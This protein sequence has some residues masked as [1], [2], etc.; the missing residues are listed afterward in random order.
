MMLDVVDKNSRLYINDYKRVHLT[1]GSR[2]KIIGR[3][4]QEDKYKIYFKTEKLEDRFKKTNAW[5][6]N[7]ALLDWLDGDDVVQIKIKRSSLIYWLTVKECITFG[8]FLW[9]KDSGIERKLYIELEYWRKVN[10]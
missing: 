8:S 6:L 10:V 7:Y 1:I 3:I 5:S 4:I 9:F 2:K